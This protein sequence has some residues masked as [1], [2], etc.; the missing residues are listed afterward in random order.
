MKQREFDNAMVTLKAM[1]IAHKA[2]KVPM[3]ATRVYWAAREAGDGRLRA[4]DLATT[5]GRCAERLVEV[6][7]ALRLTDGKRRTREYMPSTTGILVFHQHPDLF[8]K[9]A[10]RSA[11]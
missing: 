3:S 6:G 7:L 2:H 10:T 9:P 11:R 4:A 1:V 5:F 8:P